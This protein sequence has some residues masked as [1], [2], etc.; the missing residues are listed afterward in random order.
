M[1]DQFQP[2]VDRTALTVVNLD[3]NDDDH[4]W[5]AKKPLERLKAIEINRQIVYGYYS[6]P[7]GFQRIL[8]ITRR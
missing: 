8:E 2:R 4:Y 3:N 1:K 7:P 5:W 6:T